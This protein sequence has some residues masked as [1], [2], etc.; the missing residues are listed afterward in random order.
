[1]EGLLFDKKSCEILGLE[2][3]GTSPKKYLNL[4]LYVESSTETT[5]YLQVTGMDDQS[6]LFSLYPKLCE[7]LE[8][9]CCAIPRHGTPIKAKFC[10]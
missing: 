7:K 10:I 5:V 8:V 3:V 2:Y 4:D 9:E 6:C 1:M